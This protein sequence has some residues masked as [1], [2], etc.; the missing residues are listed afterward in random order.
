MLGEL[1]PRPFRQQGPDRGRGEPLELQLGD[2]GDRDV[3]LVV[4][5]CREH[6]RHRLREQ[7]PGREEQRVRRRRVEPLGVIDQAENRSG[8]GQLRQQRQ[9]P[10]GHEERVE[11]VGLPLAERDTQ[12]PLLGGGKPGD[13]A[14][15]G[16]QQPVEGRERQRGLRLEPRG[17]QHPGPIGA[18]GGVV[19]QSGL[20]HPGAAAD[21]DTR[22]APLARGVEH[23]REEGSLR[24]SPM[25][26]LP[27]VG[28]P[29]GNHLRPADPGHLT[30]VSHPFGTTLSSSA[31]PHCESETIMRIDIHPAVH[32]DDTAAPSTPQHGP[33]ARVIAGSV[34][35]G[36]V[37]ALVLT[38][39]VFAGGTESEI[40]GSTLAAFGLGWALIA[41]LTTRHTDRPQR[42]AALP[43]VAMGGTGI[44]LLVF[45]PGNATLTAAELGVAPG[46]PGPGGVDVRPDA[47]FAP[48]ARSLAAHPGRRRPGA[49]GAR[50]HLREPRAPAAT[51]TPSPPP[52]TKYD[53]GRPP[54]PPGLPGPRRPH[55]RALQRPRRDLR[56]LGPR[57]PARWR[58]PPGC[59]PTT[60]PDRAGATTPTAPGRRRGRRGPARAPGRGRR[61]RPLRAGRT[62]HR[63]HLRD[64]LRRPLPRAGRRNGAAGQLEPR[65]AHPDAR[66]RRPVRR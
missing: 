52:G 17:P 36:A 12:R 34:A 61:D 1:V 32:R 59:A 47:P 48:P 31:T 45:S 44:A 57:S 40:T 4:V 41:V 27:R 53:V 46:G 56:L 6:H 24:V 7:A 50:R 3:A 8:V 15:H 19:E 38:L 10:Q 63:W 16:T 28:P 13:Q 55:R 60:A 49:R 39:V 11:P 26:H 29:A 5:P 58:R 22:G 33:L 9:G 51:R 23:G 18:G 66:L 2:V 20:A 21:H 43:A 35:A 42:W 62:L 14:E 25:Q 30:G 54:A 37:T 64:D 65:A